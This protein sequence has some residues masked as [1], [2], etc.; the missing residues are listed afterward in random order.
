MS[1]CVVTTLLGSSRKAG[2]DGVVVSF[3]REELFIV[4]VAVEFAPTHTERGHAEG[5]V[6]N[7]ASEAGL[8]D[9]FALDFELLHGINCLVTGHAGVS[10]PSLKTRHDYIIGF[11]YVSKTW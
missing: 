7:I 11:N 1:C 5:G 10:S 9:D 4:G 2:Q 6:A 8:V 3:F